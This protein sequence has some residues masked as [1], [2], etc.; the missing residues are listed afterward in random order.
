MDRLLRKKPSFSNN[1]AEYP[2]SS[3]EDVA[4]IDGFF[5]EIPDLS[6]GRADYLILAWLLLL[7]RGSL[8]QS[9]DFTWGF[10]SFAPEDDAAV[11]QLTGTVNDVISSEGSRISDKL[12]PIRKL[13][14]G[15]DGTRG[16]D[17]ILAAL[18]EEEVCCSDSK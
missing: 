4:Q 17:M 11:E 7:H 1:L 14:S 18:H 13:R 16:K 10:S 9:S 2:K 8:E 6:E 5:V 15:H 3:D 12:E